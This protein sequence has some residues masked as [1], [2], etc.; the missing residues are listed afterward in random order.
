M[1]NHDFRPIGL[2]RFNVTPTPLFDAE[3][4]YRRYRV[5][6]GILIGTYSLRKGVISND[7]E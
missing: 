2:S 3:K 1:K 5:I 7:P 4:R 6:N